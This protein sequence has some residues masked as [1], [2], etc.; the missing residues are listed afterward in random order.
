VFS[1]FNFTSS[2]S[3]QETVQISDYLYFS[4]KSRHELITCKRLSNVVSLHRRSEEM[5]QTTSM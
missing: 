5:L 2:F 4:H 1:K 3:Q